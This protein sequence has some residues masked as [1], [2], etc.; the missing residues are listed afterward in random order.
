MRMRWSVKSLCITATFTLGMWQVTQ[1]AEAT[2]QGL[3]AC[4]AVVEGGAD[5][6]AGDF[7]KADFGLAVGWQARHF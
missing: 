7:E 6:A 5:F 1:F 2:G 4:A 3:G